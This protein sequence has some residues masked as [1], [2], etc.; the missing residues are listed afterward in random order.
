LD[1]VYLPVG[2]GYTLADT[3]LG[4]LLSVSV[5]GSTWGA[6]FTGATANQVADQIILA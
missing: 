1:F 6:Y 3:S 2:A 5:G 4:A